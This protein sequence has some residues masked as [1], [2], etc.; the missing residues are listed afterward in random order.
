MTEPRL[1]GRTPMWRLRPALPRLTFSWSR[2]ETTPTVAMQTNVAH[3]TGRQTNQSVAILLCHQLRHDA[4]GTNQ[5]AALAGIE[6]DVVDHG[7]DGDV[8]E[9]QS[10]A[11][12]DVRVG[13]SHDSVANLQAI[14]SQ[15][16]ALDAILILDEGDEGRTV[17]IVLQRLDGGRGIKLVA[18]EVDDTVLDAVAAAVMANG[19]LAGVVAAGMLLLGFQ[20]A[21]LRVDLGQDAVISNSHAT[22]AGGS[23]LVLLDSHV[24]LLVVIL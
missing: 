15:D 18:L 3:L 12:L 7:T 13:A 20:Q 21:A 16:V 23:R 1:P 17:R 8:L 19:D 2:L 22:A 6:L 9:G 5:L 14:G 24:D 4:S 10:V 11:G